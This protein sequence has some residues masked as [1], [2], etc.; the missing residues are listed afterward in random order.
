VIKQGAVISEFPMHTEPSAFNFPVRN[1]IISGLCKAVV[2]VEA[3]QKSGALITAR[4]ALDQGREVFAV[5]GPVGTP[6]VEGC[7]GLI[8]Q[9]ARLLS[10]A[11]DLLEPGALPELLQEETTRSELDRLPPEARKVYELIGVEPVH[12]DV[13]VRESGLA[14]QAVNSILINLEL[15]GLISGLAGNNYTRD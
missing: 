6:G 1:R 4:H 3:A 14:A 5:P 2:V 8:N 10:S 9:G 11:Q 12:V 7:H 15:S 13:L